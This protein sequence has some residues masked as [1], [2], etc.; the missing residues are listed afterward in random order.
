LPP[1]ECWQLLSPTSAIAAEAANAGKIRD[2][3]SGRCDESLAMTASLLPEVG[4]KFTGKLLNIGGGGVGIIFDRNEASAADR[5]RLIWLRVDLRPV[6][7]API[8]M[9]ARLVHK[10]IDSEQNL[11]TGAAFDFS[12]N[13]AHREFVVDQIVRYVN[14]VAPLA[15]AA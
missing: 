1:V 2:L 15:R 5:C 11:I 9:T 3:Q 12:V 6:I 8:A 10:H 14:A 4:P 13:A 7:P